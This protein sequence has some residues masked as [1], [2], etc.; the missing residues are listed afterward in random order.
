MNNDFIDTIIYDLEGTAHW[1]REKATEYPRDR[2]NNAAAE[3]L[4]RLAE[5]IRTAPQSLALQ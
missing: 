3:T 1:R 2:R 5:A 4:E